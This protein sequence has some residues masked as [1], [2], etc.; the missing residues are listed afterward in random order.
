MAIHPTG[1][2]LAMVGP[3]KLAIPGQQLSHLFGYEG[4][5]EAV[6]YLSEGEGEVSISGGDYLLQRTA[7]HLD[8][9]LVRKYIR[10]M[11]M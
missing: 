8:R 4:F 6:E 7:N 1:S 5:E 11:Y 9:W 2:A 10:Y 3:D